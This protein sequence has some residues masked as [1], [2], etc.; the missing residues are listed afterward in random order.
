M[1][2]Y[3]SRLRSKWPFLVFSVVFTGLAI[4]NTALPSK[5]QIAIPAWAWGLIALGCLAVAQFLA[6]RDLWIEDADPT[7]A[8]TLRG[9]A[10]GLHTQIQGGQAPSYPNQVLASWTPQHIFEAHC[11]NAAK[12]V[13]RYTEA[14][15]EGEQTEK[16][17]V[18]TVFKDGAFK[19]FGNKVGW[20]WAAI[21]KR[22]ETHMQ[23]ILRGGEMDIGTSPEGDAVVWTTTIVFNGYGMADPVGAATEAA[24]QLKEWISTV[25]RSP[26]ANAYREASESQATFCLAALHKLEPLLY[27]QRIRKS[28]GCQICFPPRRL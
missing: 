20:S 19:R 10:K 6:W 8:E 13:R 5:E 17:L 2:A 7:H 25:W 23:D 14:H 27:D 4:A 12:L 9:F 16:A 3:L 1:L 28:R 21:A 18:Q 24:T 11:P 22:C 26:E 15:A